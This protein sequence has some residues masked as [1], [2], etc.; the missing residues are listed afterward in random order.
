MQEL[1]W[2]VVWIVIVLLAVHVGG[3]IAYGEKKG[4]RYALARLRKVAPWWAV[5]VALCAG[6]TFWLLQVPP[7][8]WGGHTLE[9]G[10]LAGAGAFLMSVVD[11]YLASKADMNRSSR[12]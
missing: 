3:I 6:L 7:L 9:L 8:P 5:I 11:Q 4:S 12:T 2:D 10:L 1:W